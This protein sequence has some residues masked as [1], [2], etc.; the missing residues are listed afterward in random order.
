MCVSKKSH[1]RG[2]CILL[3]AVVRFKGKLALGRGNGLEESFLQPLAVLLSLG[4]FRDCHD[5]A[6]NHRERVYLSGGQFP[7]PKE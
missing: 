7:D 2:L 3:S 1:D 4:Y 5:F 6:E